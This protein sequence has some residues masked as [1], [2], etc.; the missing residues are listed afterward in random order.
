MPIRTR[1]YVDELR[2][3]ARLAVAATCG[4][5]DVVEAMHHAIGGGPERLGRP[6]A[7]AT[8]LFTSPVYGTIR[9]VT[10]WVGAAVD[11]ALAELA[12]LVGDG[13]SAAERAAIV[14]VLNGIVGDYLAASGNPLA[15]EMQVRHGAAAGG[16]LLVLVHGSCNDERSWQ[17]RGEDYGAALARELGYT[18]IYV[19][20]NSGL[21]ISDNGRALAERLDALLAGWPVAVEELAIVGHSMGGLVARSACHAGEAAGQAWRRVLRSLVCIGSPHHGALLEKS[22]NCVD[23][24]LGANRYSAPLARLGMIRSAGVTDLRFGSVLDDDWRGRDRFARGADPRRPLP[25]PADVACYAIAGT[26][27]PA[28]RGER[29]PGDG[30]VSIDSALGRHREPARTLAFGESRRF[31]AYATGHLDLLSSA[32]VYATLRDWLARRTT[33]TASTSAKAMANQPS[34]AA[35]APPI[36]Q[37]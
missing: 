27:A 1:N 36:A 12:A 31:I 22:G 33:T 35:A 28:P 19:R 9:G 34:P 6:L 14:A 3:A 2:G 4:V 32:E 23:Q 16:K 24:L 11:R 5:T 29:L 30:L 13:G 8:R 10:A 25:L 18:P 20:Y 37:P 7:G 26:T 17:R 21:H 15:I